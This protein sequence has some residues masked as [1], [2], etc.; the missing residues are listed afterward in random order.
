MF[1]NGV[2]WNGSGLILWRNEAF[3]PWECRRARDERS[4]LRPGGG[5]AVKLRQGKFGAAMR[6]IDTDPR[7][8]G[9]GI[10]AEA[11]ADE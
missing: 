7:N 6:R 8:G 9:F 10:F 11:D 1:W 2:F 5:E 3:V 4:R